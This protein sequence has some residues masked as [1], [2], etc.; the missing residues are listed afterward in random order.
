MTEFESQKNN[1]IEYEF[2]VNDKSNP[3]SQLY[4]VIIVNDLLWNMGVNIL[5]KERQ[6]QWSE[7]QIHLKTI[8]VVHN[9]YM[10]AM[11]Y[12]MYTNSPL[13]W[14]AKERQK[15]NDALQLF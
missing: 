1:T 13:L 11:L 4:D 12:S 2:Q 5:F 14:E 6:I 3:K 10:C 15:Y 9:R 7:D 8:G